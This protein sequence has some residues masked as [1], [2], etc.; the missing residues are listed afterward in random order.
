MTK[1]ELFYFTGKCLGL[2]HHPEFASEIIKMIA[3]EQV[4]W[5]SFVGLC[6]NHLVLP[7][8]YVV[9][10]RHGIVGHL[11]EELAEHLKMIFDLN[12]ER[13]TRILFQMKEIAKLLNKNNIYP[14][15]LKGGGNL[16]DGLYSSIGE[17]I[18]GDIDFLVPDA[19]Y[20]KSAKLMELAGYSASFDGIY[21]DVETLKDYPAL[22]HPDFATH[23][24]IHRMLV[25]ERFHKGINYEMVR[26]NLKPASG[27]SGC[28]VLSDKHNVMLNFIHCQLHHSGH[29]K[30]IVSFRDLYDLYL[31]SGKIDL[32]TVLPELKYQQKAKAYFKFADK[33]IGLKGDL[34]I[35]KNLP[36]L[37]FT[38]KHKWNIESPL[39][40]KTNRLLV[41]LSE[42]IGRY[43]RHLARFV[44]SGPA[45]RSLLRRFKNPQWYGTHL[46][47]YLK[48]FRKE[49]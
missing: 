11:P 17:R 13:N 29:P 2:D 23:I 31:L 5:H 14:I 46:N 34:A 38:F 35:S 10:E 8:V 24:E 12:E 30:G 36:Y 15:F 7:T 25:R 32:L 21:D 27:A 22:V 47:M 19:D 49:I 44:Y 6:S 28:Y 16:I 37:V 26:N 3:A 41:F 4:D 1:S 45:R 42:R 39:F 9:F 33:T 20:L 43:L 48:F 40:Y 18:L